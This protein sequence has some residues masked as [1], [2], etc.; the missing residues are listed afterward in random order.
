MYNTS[1][2]FLVF[3]KNKSLI[4]FS[5]IIFIF[6]QKLIAESIQSQIMKLMLQQNCIYKWLKWIKLLLS[7]K[8]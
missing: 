6:L 2:N 1:D 8:W 7:N 3:W 4:K 5:E